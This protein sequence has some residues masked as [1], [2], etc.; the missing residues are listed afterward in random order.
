MHQ[1]VFS[2]DAFEP[3]KHPAKMLPLLENIWLMINTGQ[4]AK[5]GLNV[6]VDFCQCTTTTWNNLLSKRDTPYSLNGLAGSWMMP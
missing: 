2:S 5:S 4:L 3:Q 1:T 6:R